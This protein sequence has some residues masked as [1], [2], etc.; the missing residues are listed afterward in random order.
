MAAHCR[1][2]KK[3]QYSAVSTV[4]FLHPMSLYTSWDKQRDHFILICL[5]LFLSFFLSLTFSQWDTDTPVMWLLV[6]NPALHHLG[7]TQTHIT[8]LWMKCGPDHC[9]SLW[10]PLL[11][12]TFSPPPSPLSSCLPLFLSLVIHYL[13]WFCWCNVSSTSYLWVHLL[14]KCWWCNNECIMWQFNMQNKDTICVSQYEP[15]VTRCHFVLTENEVMSH[16]SV[17]VP[18]THVTSWQCMLG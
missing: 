17:T 4:D 18:S 12:R 6:V 13:S 11:N 3:L 2:K 5:S 8:C 14:W 1:E 16:S 9:V 7:F 10:E 15:V